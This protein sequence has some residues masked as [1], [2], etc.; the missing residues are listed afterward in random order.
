MVQVHF[1]MSHMYLSIFSPYYRRKGNVFQAE[2]GRV[3]CLGRV[4]FKTAL[5]LNFVQGFLLFILYFSKWQVRFG[6]PKPKG[7]CT[8]LVI[9]GKDCGLWYLDKACWSLRT[10]LDGCSFCPLLWG[11]TWKMLILILCIPL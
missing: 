2:K 10:L 3:W 9:Q 7:V 1:Q 11:C 6:F 4:A 5:L 8:T